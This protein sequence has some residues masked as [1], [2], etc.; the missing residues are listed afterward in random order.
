MADAGQGAHPGEHRRTEIGAGGDHHQGGESGGVEA[1]L[2]LNDQA[3]VE[4]ADLRRGG[5]PA[6]G[7]LE[8]I[9]GESEIGRRFHRFETLQVTDRRC[10]QA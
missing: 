6:E 1:V 2:G 9:R 4:G 10:G 7:L 3:D 5:K 8:E